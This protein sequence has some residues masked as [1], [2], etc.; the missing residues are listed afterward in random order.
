MWVC[1]GACPATW[2]ELFEPLE[3]VTILTLDSPECEVLE[4]VLMTSMKVMIAA[5]PSELGTHPRIAGTAEE[6]RMYLRLKPVPAIGREIDQTIARCGG[7][8]AFAAVH[9]RR[10]DFVALFEQGE[11]RTADSSF[12]S[13]VDS[14]LAPI[15]GDGGDG[16]DGSRVC[17]SVFVATDN[18]ATQRKM[19]GRFG[20]RFRSTR[21]I[22]PPPLTASPTDPV[23]HTAVAD[24]VVDLFVCVES[25]SFMGTLGSSFSD[26]IW[27][28]RRAR[29]QHSQAQD[30]LQDGHSLTHRMGRHGSRQAE[31]GFL[32][33]G[34]LSDGLLELM[35]KTQRH[36][37]SGETTAGAAQ[38]QL[39]APPLLPLLLPLL[40]L[41]LP[42]RP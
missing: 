5:I 1:G 33:K 3:G 42:R 30:V 11:P 18:A 12:I 36:E 25:S 40:L 4:R 41:Q 20:K 22:G 29:G 37:A 7:A 10:T 6:E 27:L 38:D 21:P 24:A 19:E 34:K 23:R 2:D 31:S 8:G 14:R 35:A 28:L 17:R 32:L 15:G 9:M 26:T 39:P 16:S 13:F